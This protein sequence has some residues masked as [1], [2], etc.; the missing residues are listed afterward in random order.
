M[1]PYNIPVASGPD[2]LTYVLS[3]GFSAIHAQHLSSTVNVL[4]Y[5]LMW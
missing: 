3:Q 2:C 5:V 1:Q 4:M